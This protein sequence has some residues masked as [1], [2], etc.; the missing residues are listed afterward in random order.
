LRATRFTGS[1]V[2]IERIRPNARAL[3]GAVASSNRQQFSTSLT[4]TSRVT[5][6]GFLRQAFKLLA[7][8]SVEGTRLSLLASERAR[9]CCVPTMPFRK[10]SLCVELLE[11][12]ALC[13]RFPWISA[14]GVA[15]RLP[16]HGQRGLVRRSGADAG[17]PSKSAR[18]GY[19]V[20][21]RRGRGLE[22]QRRQLAL[23][24][25]SGS[26]HDRA[27]GRPVVGRGGRTRR[28]RA[29]RSSAPAL[30]FCSTSGEPPGPTPLV[31]DPSGTW[32]RRK[33]ASISA[34]RRPPPATTRPARRCEVQHQ[35]WDDMVWPTLAAR[36][37]AFD[38]ARW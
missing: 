32:F 34:A 11:P 12:S 28:H 24:R 18:V 3:V 35:E 2:V 27:G 26:P 9:L 5:G 22:P 20:R 37:P 30:V 16:R 1:V 19:P 23:G 4:F 36:V 25:P 10:A 6:I 7:S 31:I 13:T 33:V 17:L 38:A 29:P 21:R 8:I 14:D 15:A